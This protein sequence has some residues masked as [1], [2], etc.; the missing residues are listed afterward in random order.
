MWIDQDK[1]SSYTKY[2]LPKRNTVASGASIL[3]KKET[4][5]RR[6]ASKNLTSYV[7]HLFASETTSP[8]AKR[9]M[10]VCF[11]FTMN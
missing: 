3:S 10:F 11:S 6:R 9:K 8:E 2:P 5:V 4:S 1:T 7:L